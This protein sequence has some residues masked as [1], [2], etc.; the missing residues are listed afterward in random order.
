MHEIV[1]NASATNSNYN[2]SKYKA[3]TDSLKMMSDRNQ[4]SGLGKR[5]AL[6]DGLNADEVIVKRPKYAAQQKPPAGS[7][8]DEEWIAPKD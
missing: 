1:Q 4:A 7:V 6:L 3:M 5:T 2:L 8:E